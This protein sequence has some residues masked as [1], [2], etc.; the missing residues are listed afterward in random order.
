MINV[1]ANNYYDQ[2]DGDDF[3]SLAFDEKKVC[4]SA[5]WGTK[6]AE[7]VF[8]THGWESWYRCAEGFRS[9]GLCKVSVLVLPSAIAWY[10]PPTRE[11]LVECVKLS[12]N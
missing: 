8:L 1:I 12:W 2:Y 5:G 4:F 3:F 10:A 6:E 7:N 11:V 9:R